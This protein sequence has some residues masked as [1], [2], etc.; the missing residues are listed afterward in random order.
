VDGI[1][2]PRY[3]GDKSQYKVFKFY[4]NNGNGRRVQIIVWN[5]DIDS[6]EDNIKLNHVSNPIFF[7]F[8]YE[9]TSA[10]VCV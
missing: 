4:V 6:V 10:Y 5:D 2:A 7:L 1:E 3:V 8:S 9:T